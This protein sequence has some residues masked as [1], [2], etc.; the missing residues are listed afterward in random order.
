[1]S[2]KVVVHG[3]NRV[4][5]KVPNSEGRARVHEAYRKKAKQLWSAPIRDHARI[6][7]AEL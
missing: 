3:P 1:M 6:S 2:G 7:V 5:P 4:D